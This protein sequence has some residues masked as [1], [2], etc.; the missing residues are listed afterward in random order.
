[1]LG[2]KY[3]TIHKEWLHTVGNLTL[4]AY[5]SEL[6]DKPFKEKREYLTNSNISLN[7]YFENVSVWNE[8]EIKRR[9]DHLADKAVEIWPR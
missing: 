6:S 1:M 5:N 4:T 7:R 3:D 9:A 2:E 8:E